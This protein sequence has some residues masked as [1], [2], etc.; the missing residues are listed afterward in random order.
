MM[1]NE[2]NQERKVQESEWVFLPVL[3]T[4]IIKRT[5]TYVLLDLDGV[6][7]G[8]ISAKFLRK[9]ETDEKVFFSVPATYE[10]KCRVREL[11]NGR[12]VT[13]AEILATIGELKNKIIEYNK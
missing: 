12:W 1:N 6:A 8:I 11:V 10:V 3:K 9:K 2:T 5:E 7:T 4:H 13:K